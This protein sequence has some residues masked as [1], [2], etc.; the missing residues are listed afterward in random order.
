MRPRLLWRAV[1][2]RAFPEDGYD[3]RQFL[4]SCVRIDGF[5]KAESGR[6]IVC[7]LSYPHFTKNLS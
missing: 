4:L 2:Y 1:A 7:P 6:S 5:S 3:A